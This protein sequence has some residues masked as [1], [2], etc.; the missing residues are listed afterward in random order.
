MENAALGQS[1]DCPDIASELLRVDDDNIRRFD[2]PCV[3]AFRKCVSLEDEE[4]PPR[5]RQRV[6]KRDEG[7]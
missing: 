1:E 5:T 6:L 2:Y 3:A 7:R 4:W